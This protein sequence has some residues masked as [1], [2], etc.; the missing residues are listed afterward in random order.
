MGESLPEFWPRQELKDLRVIIGPKPAV[1]RDRLCRLGD[2][3]VACPVSKLDGPVHVA[4]EKFRRR[5]GACRYQCH[6][7]EEDRSEI[8]RLSQRAGPREQRLLTSRYRC[9][10]PI[11]DR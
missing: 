10:R 6:S 1:A 4:N 3:K 11:R 7:E 8:A 5:E 9:P 2:G